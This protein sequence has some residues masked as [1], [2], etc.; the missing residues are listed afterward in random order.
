MRPS[1]VGTGTV[2]ESH[3]PTDAF[4]VCFYYTSVL[5][6]VMKDPLILHPVEACSSCGML[7]CTKSCM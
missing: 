4:Y 2:S 5:I 7:T 1:I 6:M 3:G